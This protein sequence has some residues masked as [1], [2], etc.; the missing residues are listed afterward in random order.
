MKFRSEVWPEMTIDDI[1][2]E[3]CE[4]AMH[5]SGER[6]DATVNLLPGYYTV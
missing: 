3:T 5:L 6:H 4:T 2:A 1:L